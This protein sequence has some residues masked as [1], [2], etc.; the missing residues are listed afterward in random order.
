MD[1]A[2]YGEPKYVDLI[3]NKLVDLKEDGS[4]AMDMRYFNYCQGLTMTN[5]RFAEL[6]GGPP[7]NSES[8][9]TQ[10]E[11]DMAASI[12]EVTTQVVLRMART[13]KKMTGAKNL[14]LAGGVALN[15]VANGALLREKIFDEIWIAPPAGDAGGALG[16]ALF[17]HYQLLEGVRTVNGQDTMRGSLL[18]PKFSNNEIRSFLDSKSLKGGLLLGAPAAAYCPLRVRAKRRFSSAAL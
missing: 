12:Q 17:V 15:C 9:I 18:G 16:A 13:V 4:F 2:P 1:L 10:R 14:C 7:R 3:L 5:A 11:M 8:L 6:F